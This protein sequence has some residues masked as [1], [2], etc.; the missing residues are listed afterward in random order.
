MIEA[1]ALTKKFDEK[2]ALNALNLNIDKGS[3]YGLVG[4]NGGG[5][6]TFMNLAT[7]VYNPDRGQI[8]IDGKSVFGN[9]EIKKKIFFIPDD[10]FYFQNYT[11]E[12]MANFYKGLYYDTWSDDLFEKLIK[13][14]PLDKNQKMKSC[15]KGML[16]Q[17]FLILALSC[18]PEYLFL[19]EVFD[20]LDAVIRVAIRKIIADEVL[21]RNM[22]VVIASHNL[23]ELEDFCDTVGLIHSGKLVLKQSLDEISLSYSKAQ[24]AFETIPD[25]SALKENPNILSLEINGSFVTICA[26][27]SEREIEE[28]LKPY[29]SK[30]S[31]FVNLSLE[32]VFISEMEAIGYDYNKIIL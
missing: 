8:L 16:K 17:A 21:N 1:I 29:N 32:E 31:Q 7:G 19:D 26:K 23:R 25:F 2:I 6:S 5:K 9:M 28:L 24:V 12:A 30:M 3:I 27:M 13:S 22:T 14:L 11:I 4:T 18:R 20:G 15:S 10:A